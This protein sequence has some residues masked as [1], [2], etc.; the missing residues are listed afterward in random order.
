MSSC[1]TQYKSCTFALT[2]KPKFII[3]ELNLFF[4]TIQHR[5]FLFSFSYHLQLESN[6]VF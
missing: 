4:E 3:L 5:I 1:V 2:L 6:T